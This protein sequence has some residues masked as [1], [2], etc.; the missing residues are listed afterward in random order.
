MTLLKGKKK[1]QLFDFAMPKWKYK[2]ILVGFVVVLI[3][4]ALMIGGGSKDPNVFDESELFSFRRITLSPIIIV[5]GLVFE[6]VVIMWRGGE[7]GKKNK[8]S[9][10][11]K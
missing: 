6:I 10:E 8:E 1:E 2:W 4:Y 7:F 5:L 9:S 3:G 11:K